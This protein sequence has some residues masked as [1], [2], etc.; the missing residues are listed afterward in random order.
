MKKIL[1]TLLSC[2]LCISI[3]FIGRMMIIQYNS[4]SGLCILGYHG[5]VSDQEKS[6]KYKNNRYYLSESQFI[7]QMEYL[8]ENHYQ[9][10]SMDEVYDYYIG[11]SN[12]NDKSIVLTFDDGYK[13]FNTIVIPILEKYQFKATCFV[14][15]KHLEDDKTKFLK[16]KDIINTDY[17][18]YYSHSYNLHQK[19]KGFDRKIIQD[20][21]LEE[22]DN[23]FKVNPLDST[24][25]AFPYGRSVNNIE[26]ILK[27][28]NVKLAFSY[29]QF[30]HMTRKDNQYYLPRYMI[31][32]IMPF[33]YFQYITK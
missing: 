14:I 19:A 5:I 4:Q 2:L 7:K 21:S 13:N 3:V 29:N 20:S 27:Q 28:N 8:Y 32:D 17:I 31:V 26:S 12:I 6:S 1:L 18:S 16:T 25:F 23:D 22:I 10:L 11:N 30:R 33:I 24:Y 9:T 15:G